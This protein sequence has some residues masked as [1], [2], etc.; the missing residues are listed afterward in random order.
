MKIKVWVVSTCVPGE[1]EPCIPSVF[2]T[3]TA[4]DAYLN[5]MMADEWEANGPE[6][7]D[8]SNK[9]CPADWREAMRIIH[10]EKNLGT[11]DEK[12]GQWEIT[13]HEIEIANVSLPWATP[14]A[15]TAGV[16]VIT[17]A[18]DLLKEAITTHIYDEGNGDVIPADDP[19][20]QAVADLDAMIAGA[21][22][23]EKGQ[24]FEPSE[25]GQAAEFG[26]GLLANPA[27]A[28]DDYLAR[29]PE[30]QRATAD[31]AYTDGYVDGIGSADN[32]V[33][34]SRVAIIL[35]GGLVQQV[36][37]TG[38]LIGHEV[39]V[40]DYDT[41]GAQEDSL[42]DID[43]GDGSLVTA[44]VRTIEITE[45]GIV[46]PGGAEP[47][48][49]RTLET[50]LKVAEIDAELNARDDA[51]GWRW[52]EPA[53]EY[54]LNDTGEGFDAVIK[55]GDLG[56]TAP[57]LILELADAV[58]SARHS[59]VML[60]KIVDLYAS[61][62]TRDGPVEAMH[63]VMV[64]NGIGKVPLL[65]SELQRVIEA[66]QAKQGGSDGASPGDLALAARLREYLV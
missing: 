35:E 50:E 2:V 59:A 17:N 20:M 18:R 40:I 33:D 43:Q 12:W 49:A 62:V 9:P 47:D 31:R 4:A 52:D 56:A 22:A 66:L 61:I 14:S 48:P 63:K 5:Q 37:A 3:E 30:D 54:R 53:Q 58:E 16:G 8:G 57:A 19:Y 38:A 45:A 51:K 46:I 23:P 55:A 44:S 39:T 10:E 13:S 7:D 27:S 29:F 21:A 64:L 1:T 24:K 26:P 42:T 11:V 25:T 41:E 6:N 65:Q 36:V 60:G 28:G 32:D 15:A 34:E